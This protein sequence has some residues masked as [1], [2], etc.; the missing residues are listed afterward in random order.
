MSTR[1]NTYNRVIVEEIL[2]SIMDSF[3]FEKVHKCMELLDWTWCMKYNL[4]RDRSELVESHVP[5]V[6]E[7]KET[8]ANLLWYTV[9]CKDDLV[10]TGGFQVE[11]DF[12]NPNDPWISLKF[13]VEECEN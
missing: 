4:S 9:N 7:L 1:K 8:A 6:E 11:K 13:I 5:T 12:S 10:A 3:D 2:D